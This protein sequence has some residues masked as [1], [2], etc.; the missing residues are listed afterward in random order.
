MSVLLRDYQLDC[1][2]KVTSKIN[3]GTKRLSVVMT[4]GLGQKTTSLFLADKLYSEDQKNIA[5]VFRYKAAMMQTM[6]NADKLEIY[7][8]D[9]Y[10]VQGFIANAKAY[11]HI[12]LHDVSA[13]E[14]RQIQ[15]YVKDSD[16]VIISF[17]SPDQENIYD[18]SQSKISPHLMAY[19]EKLS[20]VVCVYITNNVLD[21]R[22]AK[23]AGEAES[24]YVNR[25]NIAMA[26]WLQQKR[27]Q[28]VSERD[29]VKKRNDRLQAYLKAFRLAQDQQI[30]KEQAMEIERLKA[31]LQVDERDK[32]IEELEEREVEYQEQLKE[33]DARIAQ[34]DQMIAFQQDIL[35][36]FGIDEAVVQE[37]FEKIQTAR[38]SLQK[39]LESSNDTVKERALKQLQDEVAEIVNALT[40]SA[41]SMKDQK[42]FEG[43]LIDELTEEVWGRL[44]DKSKAFL[45]TAKSNYES[46]IQ[47][48][49]KETFDYSGVC[50]LVTKALEV[51]TTKRFFLCYKDYLK[52]KYNSTTSWPYSLRQRVRG[53]ITDNIIPD[54]EFTLGSVVSVIG[55][56]RDYDDNGCIVA[57]PIAHMGTKNEFIEYAMNCLF[58]FPNRSMVEKEIDKDY[59][60][61]EKVRLDYR[62]PA[63]HR[64]RLTITSAKECL[65]Y[66]F[67]VQHMLKEMLKTMKI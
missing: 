23:Y 11:Q 39:D 46:M 26:N 6:S 44:E 51:E 60:F 25:E 42:Y 21:I 56:K 53:H 63:A 10:D 61:V 28:I 54:N 18:Q 24:V 50:L 52:R 16:C 32:R 27:N 3:E 38:L 47:M 4:T 14:R 30:I 40:K 9:Y 57:Y 2:E 36:A 45:I 65:A 37:S 35:S 55:L 43:Y 29:E 49:D 62:N 13:Y 41:L 64:D 22:D 66:V 8:V 33:K 17:S 34:Q 59:Q 1:L 58:K 31:L 12:I 15:E 48:K 20:P 19:M 67:D 5:M 7:S